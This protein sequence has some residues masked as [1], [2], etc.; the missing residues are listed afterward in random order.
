MVSILELVQGTKCTTFTWSIVNIWI[1][2]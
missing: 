1:I 2:Q